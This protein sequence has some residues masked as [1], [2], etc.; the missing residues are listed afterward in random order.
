MKRFPFCIVIVEKSK[1]FKTEVNSVP[2]VIQAVSYDEAVGKAQRVANRLFRN[3]PNVTSY[4]ANV[5]NLTVQECLITD[6][7]KV[8]LTLKSKED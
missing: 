7:D 4:K 3:D 6:I 1:D 2:G 8:E 5:S